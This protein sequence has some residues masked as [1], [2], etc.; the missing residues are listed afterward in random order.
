MTVN[1]VGGAIG[2]SGSQVEL[3]DLAAKH[4]FESVEAKPHDLAPLSDG[5]L[6]DLRA[7]MKAKGIIWGASGLPVD[8]RGTDDE[9]RKGLKELPVLMAALQR[10]GVN[11][12]GTWL[13]PSHRSL[14]Y[15]QNFKLHVGRLIEVAKVLGDHGQKLGLEYVGTFTLWTGGKFPFVHSMEEA[16]D[17]IGEIGA[18]NVGFVLDSWHWWSANETKEDIL[19]LKNE[20]IVAVDL[21]DAPKGVE[22]REQRDN[23]RELPMATGV[24]DVASFLNAL[25]ALGYDGPVRAEPFN[26]ELN[27]ME[28]DEACAATSKA[29][30]RAFELIG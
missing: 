13:S 29:I 30:K 18:R 17:L 3:I 20:Q 12:V 27:A 1:L 21:N 28:N 25:Q 6:A 10:A 9:F 26:Q 7:T 2:V 14:T 8:F 16:K 19:S 24:I 11:R 5:Q 23:Q 15:Y 22:K 4:G